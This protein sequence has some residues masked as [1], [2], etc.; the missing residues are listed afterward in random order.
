MAVALSNGYSG[1]GVGAT[2]SVRNTRV[3]TMRW[4]T[5]VL[6][7]TVCCWAL[8]DAVHSARSLSIRSRSRWG[9]QITCP[10]ECE[11]RDKSRKVDC[12]YRG[13]NYIPRGI[14]K[15]AKRIAHKTASNADRADG[16]VSMLFASSLLISVHSPRNQGEFDVFGS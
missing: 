14:S 11:C 1:G 8:P 2:M 16:A 12:T 13:L 10:K 5:L 3:R 7:L 6:L 9:R 15:G 4:S